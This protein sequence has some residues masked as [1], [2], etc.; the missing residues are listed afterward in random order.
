VPLYYH[1][2]RPEKPAVFHTNEDCAE[3]KKIK[4]WDRVETNTVPARRRRCKVCW[5][6][7]VL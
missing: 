7:N 6:A 5:T 2:T 4:S 3:G 1:T